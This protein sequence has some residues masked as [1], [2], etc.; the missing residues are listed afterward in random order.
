M[1]KKGIWSI[2]TLLLLVAV[3]GCNDTPKNEK[4]TIVATT[5]IVGDC[6]KQIVGDQAEVTSLMGAGVDPHLY[7][8]SQG[9]IAKLASADI[10]VYN[11]LH[12]EGKMAKML[13]NY[14]K[15]KPAF[16]VGSYVDHSKLKRV[17]ETSDLVDPHIW[18]SP[19]LWM[20]GI[21]GLA[22]ELNQI[23]GLDKTMDNFKEYAIEI[24]ESKNN[25]TSAIDSSLTSKKR[26]L[27]TSHDA[28]AYFGD[29]F[30]FKVRGLQGISTAAEYGAKD[31]KD[32]IDFIIK[33]EIKSVFIETSVSDK[34]LRAVIE[35]AQARDYDLSIGGT[36]YS[37]ALGEEGTPAGTYKGMLE[38]NVQ[39]IIDGLK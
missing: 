3:T 17:D 2:F 28:F 22:G 34:N 39:T 29:A 30:G 21:E 32:L 35:G 37:D 31:V 24:G 10:I 25:L 13:V 12:L 26:I 5:G 6:V 20:K 8:A 15:Q 18:F 23:P 11:G 1:I 16:A 36:L 14:S 33:N 4:I 27:I 9:D 7:K 38:A 19:D